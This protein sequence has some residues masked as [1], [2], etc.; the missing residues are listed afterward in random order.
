[1]YTV[2]NRSG[3]QVMCGGSRSVKSVVSCHDNVI[4]NRRL[5]NA[6]EGYAHVGIAEEKH[7]YPAGNQ[8]DCY[9]RG[10]Y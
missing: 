4:M 10:V 9:L 5:Q 7:Q 8:K 2:P 1:M 3:V 6:D